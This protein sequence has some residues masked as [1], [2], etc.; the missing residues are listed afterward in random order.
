MRF[1][2][3]SIA[4]VAGLGACST[5]SDYER[6]PIV[7]PPP[8]VPAPQMEPTTAPVPAGA[9]L[10]AEGADLAGLV[11]ASPPGTSFVIDPGLHRLAAVTPKDG[12]SFLGRSGAVLSGA[13]PLEGFEPSGSHW[14]VTGLP[15]DPAGHGECIAGYDACRLRNDLFIDDVM[16]WRVDSIDD[17]DAG[18]WWGGAGRIVIADDPTDRV[19]ELSVAP[20]AFAGDAADVTISGLIVEKYASPAQEAAVQALAPGNGPHGTNWTLENLEVR[21]NHAAGIRTGEATV[22]RDVY[23]HHNGQLGI[24]GNAG[25]GVLVEDTELAYNNTRGFFWEWE[26]G[27]AKFTQTDG[28]TVRRTFSH[29]NQGPGLWTDIDAVATTFDSNT[30]VANSGPGIFH[31]ISGAAVI[32]NNNVEGNGFGKPHWIWGAGILI[33]ASSDVEVTGNRL[34]GNADGIVGIQQERGEGPHG[35]RLLDALFVHHNEV[36]LSS[37]TMGVVQDSGARG[38]FT[39]RDIRFDHNRYFDVAD[40]RAYAWDGESRN[41]FGWVDAG[42]DTHGTWE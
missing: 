3:L 33:A 36:E 15:L 10:V 34:V 35:P 30:V 8:T 40:R 9:I 6:P 17:L 19:V 16:L 1:A 37:G 27:G 24:A 25:S 41:R 28:L 39:E 23:S 14:E 22:V 4:L 31:E 20:F 18:E 32:R 13:V 2:L 29:H 38:I 7:L 21:L 11:A 12:M 42:F 5:P 26:G